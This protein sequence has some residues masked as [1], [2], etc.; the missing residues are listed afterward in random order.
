M[1]IDFVM[2]WVNGN[3]PQWQILRN[4]HSTEPQAVDESRYRDWDILKYWF[5]AVETH[6][7]W[8]NRIHFVTCS[9]WPNWLNME[10]P[11][12]NPVDHRDFIPEEYLPTFNSMA[13]ELNF[14]R[15]PGLEEHFVYFNDDM[16]VNAPVQPEDFFLNGQP[17]A[18]AIMSPLVP[19]NPGDAH[20]HTICNNMAVINRH[21]NKKQVIKQSF[22]KW[23]SLKYGKQL[24]KNLTALPGTGFSNFSLPHVAN[25][26]LRST[27]EQVWT[28]EGELL[29]KA[30]REKFRCS[31]GIN[32]Y[33]MSQFDMCSGRFAPRAP[34]FGKYYSIGPDTDA[35]CRELEQG[36]HKAIC[37]NDHEGITDFEAEKRRLITAFEA[38]YPNPSSFELQSN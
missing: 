3:D 33:L 9:Q 16:Y 11:K 13:I 35:I 17:R 8:V 38:A 23:F 20:M 34:G 26:M 30:C 18:T 2:P 4:S 14:H 10:H 19:V 36:I 5:R 15:I 1:K 6:A 21:F 22:S 29:D 12:L 7:P 27:F 31:N 32:Q 25:S 24:I 37:L 28:L